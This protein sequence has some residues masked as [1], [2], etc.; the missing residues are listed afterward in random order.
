MQA[1]PAL[2]GV[3]VVLISSASDLPELQSSSQAGA[4]VWLSKPFSA[5]QLG[6]ALEAARKTPAHSET[7][8]GADL[9]AQVRILLVDDSAAARSHV[10]SVL[11]EAGLN[12]IVEAKDGQ[13]A[14]ALLQKE[15]FDLVVTDYNMPN[16]DGRGLIDYIRHHSRMS[17]VPVLMV[18]TET[19]P[20]RLEAVRRL[21]VEA[22]CDKSFPIEVIRT[23]LARRE[24][25]H[26]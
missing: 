26:V 21:G 20:A 18:T 22:I 10:R 5:E 11:A 16:L 12:N 7:M 23:I 1:D 15:S 19:D 9:T 24:G 14:V 4:F 3:G 8:A 2:A 25:G 6:Q 13:Q 17:S